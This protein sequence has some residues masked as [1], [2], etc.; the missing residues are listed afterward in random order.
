MAD[1]QVTI[2][3]K[4]IAFKIAQQF[5]AYYREE[6]AE[7]VK[8][9]EHYYR[10]VETQPNMGVYNNRRLFE[11]RDIGTTLANM[12]VFFKKKY[13]AD[14]PG[15]DDDQTVR[16][17]IRNIMDLYRRKGTQAGI[18]LFFRMF[19]E[20][21]VEI[22]Y[23]AQYMFKPSDSNWKTGTYLQLFPNNNDFVSESGA[24]YDYSDVLSKNIYGS[25]SKAKAI[26]DKIN[27]VYLNGTL[28]PIIY[29]TDPKGKF[30]KYDDI[31]ARIN[32][33]DI[34][35]GRLNGSADGLI[36]DDT[37]GGTTGNKIG[38]ILDVQSDYGKGAKAIV[39]EL[40]E[41]FTG[42]VS[43]T[44]EDGGF[45]YTIEN[46]K[47]FVSNQVI[48]LNN[49]GFIFEE[50][51][52]LTDTA[53]NQGTVIGQNSSSVGIKMEP[54]DSFDVNRDI[55]TN[56]ASGN[57]T[58]TKYDPET[59]SGQVFGISALNET[60]PGPLYANTGNPDHA[61]VEALTNVEQVSLITD[62][63]GGFVNVPLNSADYN[64]NPPATATMSGTASP[65][66]LSTPMN[67][68]FDLTPF[69]IGTILSLENLNPGSDYV[70]D[71]FVL[72]RD[73]QMI[74]FE[75][76]EQNI[77]IEN[78]SASFSVGDT[79]TQALTGTTGVITRVDNDLGK[80]G[81]RPFSYYGFKS[82][83]SGDAIG[84]KGNFY[85]VLAVE[86]DYTSDRFGE[87]ADVSAETLFSTGRIKA[88]EIRDSGFGYVD[89]ETVFLVNDANQKQ[90][91]ATL[92]AGSQGITSGFWAS[93]SSHLNGYQNKDMPIEK[94]DLLPSMDEGVGFASQV[95]R[96]AVGLSTQ[97]PEF[98]AFL[99][100]TSSDGFAYGDM[101]KDGN[102]DSFDALTFLRLGAGVADEA[103]KIRWND[104]VVPSLKKQV[105]FKEEP[106]LYVVI[107]ELEYYDSKMKIQDSDYY[108]EYS[109][110][111][112]STVNVPRYETVLKDTM[113]MA[114]SKMFGNFV[115]NQLTGPGL[116]H[117][118]QFRVK[119]DYII[120][121]P[122]IVGP[123]QD[124]GD[125]TVRADNFVWTVDSINITSDNA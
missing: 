80:L 7:L 23:P 73:E 103:D 52:I 56:R 5:P 67:Q 89:G 1:N 12:I 99:G 53:G 29:I 112:R 18:Q 4:N 110:E 51:E 8:M 58:L 48:I 68:A 83:I 81:V 19:Y 44:L 32:G 11:Y 105:W 113:H 25:I 43:Y 84:H 30:A 123:D 65:V 106:Q 109:Y 26:I 70:N 79:I 39:T 111:I 122:E 85:D 69:E 63:I 31:I 82:A 36:I 61:K 100:T 116:S 72:V 125:Q 95:L 66:T 49:E 90:A 16:F 59:D 121:G 77:L 74:A 20:E 101:N 41:E 62:V 3:E 120:G 37:Y 97:P 40:Q 75:R 124:V 71:V 47:I 38:D 14:L 55:S 13:M 42:T 91:R 119:D 6:G 98:A 46:T 45:G 108:Q 76:F 24:R 17:L 35:F 60:S 21:D 27:F 118:F 115:Y 15:V 57:F 9:V 92:S 94:K 88:A 10:F 64:T 34:A 86:T 78:Y 22:K 117:K 93:Q 96:V 102:I 33:E 2:V 104:I 87:S 107:E 54:G 28:T 50:L 114:G